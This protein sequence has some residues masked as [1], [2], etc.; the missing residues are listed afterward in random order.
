MR[1]WD[2]IKLRP[3][4]ALKLELA[5]LSGAGLTLAATVALS[6]WQARQMIAVDHDESMAS[7]SAGTV[8][9]IG[10]RLAAVEPLPRYLA[11]Q[12]S[13]ACPPREQL[14]V[15]ARRA[16]ASTPEAFG[17]SIT[18]D[19]DGSPGGQAGVVY[20]HREGQAI[21]EEWLPLKTHYYPVQD[22]YQ[23]PRELG[24]AAWSEPFYDEATGVILSTFAVPFFQRAAAGR[25]TVAGLAAGVVNLDRLS[26]IV[27]SLGRSRGCTAFLVSS[28]GIFV[29]HPNPRL[30][31]RESVFS[32]AES[33]GDPELRRIGK[34]MIRGEQGVARVDNP[35][36]GPPG[37]LY[38]AALPKVDGWSLGLIY[39]DREL[40]AEL[41]VLTL[42]QTGI[43]ATGLGLLVLLVVWVARGVTRPLRALALVTPELARGNLRVAVPEIRSHD[44][45]GDLGR[46]F[47]AMTASLASLTGQ[48]KGASLQLVATA[49]EIAATSRQQEATISEFGTS[50]TEVAAAVCQISATARELA[51]TMD[52]VT[53]VAGITQKLAATGGGNLRAME[54]SMRRLAAA[55]G[56]ISQTLAGLLGRAEAITG[57][58]TTITKVAD[59]TNLLSLN[60]AIEAEKA[61]PA[62]R[63]FVIVAREIRRLADQ[64]AIATLDIEKTVRDMQEAVLA[65]SK[66]MAAF[67]VEVDQDVSTV[68]ETG[69]HLARI[70][71]QVDQLLPRFDTVNNGMRAQAAGA[72]QIHLAM[73]QL[74]T[75]ARQTSE[76]LR[77]F[78]NA[79]ADLQAAAGSLQQEISRFET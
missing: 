15:M 19:P 42:R 66:E 68:R 32:L 18:R 31:M 12:L 27:D 72:E 69:G 11:L 35:R 33:C 53:E 39:P 5:L 6:G 25:Q 8:A 79:T 23:V 7:L 55:T 2:R 43:A 57:L 76:S 47:K 17:C 37:R 56:A 52:G 1:I 10:N 58:I 62:G 60:A 45:I 64:T 34:A 51:K 13:D 14:T 36:L 28:T 48:V 16:L 78:K 26:K 49:T 77:Q 71:E 67:A 46:S 63:G 24:R 75:G 41:R 74:N 21:H 65:G 9:R 54:E 40:N 20:C 3:G 59:Q 61:G 4:L 30:I 29:T 38:F 22:W 50:T 73:D 44:E 70:L